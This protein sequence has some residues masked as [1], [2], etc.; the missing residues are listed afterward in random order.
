MIFKYIWHDEPETVKTYDTKNGYREHRIFSKLL[1]FP[2]M[3][4]E[5]W[6]EFE[7]K[8]IE[9]RKRDGLV[10]SHTVSD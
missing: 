7:L 5:A 10:L 1:H 9:E 8:R 3:T 6:D 2:P 4:P